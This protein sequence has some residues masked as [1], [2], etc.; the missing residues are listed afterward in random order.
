MQNAARHSSHTVGLERG[1]HELSVEIGH[2]RSDFM[3]WRCHLLD[4]STNVL[5]DQRCVACFTVPDMYNVRLLLWAC[6]L[7]TAMPW[8]PLLFFTRVSVGQGMN[9]MGTA[10]HSI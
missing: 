9:G 8:M 7:Y 10:L 1:G 2:W 6:G 3:Q 4:F 5:S